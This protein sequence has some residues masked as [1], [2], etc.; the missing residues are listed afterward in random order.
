ML[1]LPPSVKI[2]VATEPVDARKSFNGLSCAVREALG[3]DPQD[4]HMYVFIN[5]RGDVIQILFWDRTGFAIM[6]KR[7]EA[8]TFRLA[9]GADGDASHVEIDVAALWLMLEGIDVDGARRRKRYSREVQSQIVQ[10]SQ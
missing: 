2:F 6:R 9:R 10:N 7:L 8:G 1:A 4:G 5:R 3:G